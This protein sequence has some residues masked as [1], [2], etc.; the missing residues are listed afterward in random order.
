MTGKS[1]LTRRFLLILIIVVVLIAAG[2]FGFLRGKSGESGDSSKSTGLFTVERGDLVISVIESGDIKAVESVDIKSNVEGRATIVNIV[3][4][5]TMITEQDV[6]DGRI[7]VEMDSSKLEEQIA[8][9]EIELSTAKATLADANESYLI[10]KKQNESDITAARLEVKFAEMDFQKYL[11]EE[12]AAAIFKKMESDPEFDPN[13]VSL[14]KDPNSLGGEASKR[15]DTL[16][17]AIF[18]ARGNLERATDFLE[19]TEKLRDAN[20]ASELDLKSAQL[21]K[22]SKNVQVKAAE[23]EMELYMLYDFSK[24]AQKFLS[25][26]KE[27]KLELDRTE[28][29]ARA[30]LAQATAKLAN[31]K[32]TY[33]MQE[34]RMEKLHDQIKACKIKAPAPG[35]VVYWS[36]TERWVRYKIEQGAEIPEGYKIITI[37]DAS[38]MKV[39]VK[40]HETWIDKIEPNQPAEITIAAFPDKVF[41]GKVLKK[42]PLADPDQSLNPDLKVYSTDVGIEGTHDALKTGMTGK[43]KILINEL[44]DVLYVPIQSVVT[45]DG[46]EVCYVKKDGDTEKREVETGL[47]NDNFVEI[48]SGL[49]EGEKVLLNPPRWTASD[50]KKKEEADKQ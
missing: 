49:A 25:D 1:G 22:A 45:V 7:L 27:A 2:V 5:G 32:A 18:L 47:F 38:Q 28:A 44:K 36:S 33:S 20:Y 19:G 26:Y 21:D 8:Q 30:Q 37:P 11:G 14:I 16:R 9:R 13:I 39:E 41:T 43:V 3:P 12:I 29:R 34:K 10:Q 48:K 35:Q 24:E 31:A 17:D 50:T 42:A 40:I 15:I 4:E 23:K 6:N 46:K